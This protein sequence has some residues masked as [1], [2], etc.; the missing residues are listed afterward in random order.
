MSEAL[1]K[2][3]PCKS[4]SAHILDYFKHCQKG[5]TKIAAKN[6]HLTVICSPRK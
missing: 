1:K 3:N 6:Y 4:V 5:R 2:K